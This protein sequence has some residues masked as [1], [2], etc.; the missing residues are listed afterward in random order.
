VLSRQVFEIYGTAVVV[1]AVKAST[2]DFRAEGAS[3]STG[4]ALKVS[5]G[6]LRSVD[7]LRS[8]RSTGTALKVSTGELRSVDSLR[9]VRSTGT[10]PGASTVDFGGGSGTSTVESRAPGALDST[11]TV[12]GASTV[13]PTVDSTGGARGASTVDS[14]APGALDSTGTGVDS[15]GSASRVL[16]STGEGVSVVGCVTDDFVGGTAV[17]LRSCRF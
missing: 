17:V 14:R 16:D 15:T 11:G 4:T 2:V 13:D 6:E 7:S 3:G 9:S 1:V 12:P 8:V 5:T 10:T